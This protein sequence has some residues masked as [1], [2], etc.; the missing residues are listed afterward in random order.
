MAENPHSSPGASNP[1]HLG[2]PAWKI[3]AKTLEKAEALAARGLTMR[4]IALALGIHFATLCRK[5]AKYR[6]LCEAIEKGKASGIAS[7]SNK[8]WDAAMGGN[9]TAMIFWLKAQGGWRDTAIDIN[10]SGEVGL[11]NADEERERQLKIVRAMTPEDREEYLRIVR[12]AQAR[13]KLPGI[14]TDDK[15]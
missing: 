13:V 8:L 14:K 2:R 7:V 9:I 10:L 6:V 5:K 3:D 11:K 12:D 15:N 1:K 4:Q